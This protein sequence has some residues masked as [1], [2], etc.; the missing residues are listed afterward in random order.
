MSILIE[1]CIVLNSPNCFMLAT[2]TALTSSRDSSQDGT[3]LVSA[4]ALTCR[5]DK[6]QV[7]KMTASYKHRSRS[8]HRL[9][10]SG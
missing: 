3:E 1:A 9:L 6:K 8:L 2:S 5:D 4:Q 10:S 7:S